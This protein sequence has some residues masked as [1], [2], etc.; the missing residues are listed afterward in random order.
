M[1]VQKIVDDIRKAQNKTR[2]ELGRAVGI[3]K[4]KASDLVAKRLKQENISVNVVLEMLNAMG[5]TMIVAPT[6]TTVKGGMEV[7]LHE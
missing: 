6:G 7:T 3:E 2:A 1:K 4:E 5:Y